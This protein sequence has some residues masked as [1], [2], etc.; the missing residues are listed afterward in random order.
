MGKDALYSTGYAQEMGGNHLKI[1]SDPV[2]RIHELV[3][4][5]ETEHWASLV[6]LWKTEDPENDMRGIWIWTTVF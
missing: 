2:K 1:F 4:S 6:S 3:S 5:Q